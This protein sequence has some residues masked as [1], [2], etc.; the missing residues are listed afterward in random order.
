MQFLRVIL[1]PLLAVVVLAQEKQ[2]TPRPSLVVTAGIE[3]GKVN[4]LQNYIGTL[5]YD[6]QSKLASEFEGVVEKMNFQEG[7]QVKKGDILIQLDNKVLQANINAKASGVKALKAD[8]TRQERDMQRTQALFDR[9]SISQSSFD[10]VFYATEQIRAQVA[11]MNSELNAMKIQLDKTQIKAP[12]NG[13]ITE[14]NVEE[15]EWVGKGATVATLI[16]TSSI[17]ARL[18]IPS[19]FIDSMQKDEK[20]M[21][22]ILNKD[23]ELQLKTVIPVADAAT[24]TFL[25]EFDVP[26]NLGLIQGMRIDVKVP[27][28]KQQESLLV[29]RDGVIKRFGQTII[30]AAVD[31][32]AV[33]LPVQVIGYKTD[34]AAISGM[35]VQENMRVIIKGNERVFPNMPVIEKVK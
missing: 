33:M 35:G 7:A 5:Y 25:V 23:I 1:V 13:L 12:F 14:K 4:P 32:K 34:M 20:F 26:K 17:E 11:A 30:F 6:K 9:K 16:D 28:L 18:N 3:K 22:T 27:T 21:A 10:Q 2:Q 8:L 15:G 19:R 24:R 31:G 29:P